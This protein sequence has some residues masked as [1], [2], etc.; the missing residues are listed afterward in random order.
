ML[1]FSVLC[2]PHTKPA[3]PQSLCTCCSLCP[4]CCSQPSVCQLTPLLCT[5]LVEMPPTQSSFPNQLISGNTPSLPAPPMAL[6]P[7]SQTHHIITH[8]SI[9]GSLTRMWVLFGPC[10][11]P[12]TQHCVLDTSLCCR[13]GCWWVSSLYY[14][15]SLCSL[16]LVS[17]YRMKGKIRICDT[18]QGG[19]PRYVD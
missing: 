6:F 15:N 5:G 8:L 11:V 1:I 12:R 7:H 17:L 14:G 10:C 3:P 2:H 9:V 4:E 18:R 19:K 13:N 16:F